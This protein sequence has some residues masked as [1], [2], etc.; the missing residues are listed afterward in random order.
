MPRWIGH[1]TIW[2]LAAGL[3]AA[4]QNAL[5]APSQSAELFD[6]YAQSGETGR[7]TFRDAGEFVSLLGSA[8]RN[9]ISAAPPAER[10]RRRDLVALLALEAAGSAPRYLG[11]FD[12]L[13]IIEWACDLLRKDA[14][15]EF[16]RQWMLASSSLFLRSYYE[17]H[18]MRGPAGYLGGPSAIRHLEHALDRF[19][20]EPRLRLAKILLRP[21]AYA[22]SSRPGTDPDNLVTEPLRRR[23]GGPAG[24]KRIAQTIEA[25][26]ELVDEG[27]VGAEARAHIAWLQFHRG[28]VPASRETFILAARSATDPFVRNLAWLGTGLSLDAEAGAPR[29]PTRIGP[30]S[31]R[32]PGRAH[33]P[34]NLPRTCSWLANGARRRA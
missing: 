27:D 11:H 14:P 17:L 7:L 28:D 3:T 6:R 32:Y 30:P 12:G 24:L 4:G 8:G 2:L 33:L 9:W 26:A 21:E 1:A 29:P 20:R 34:F 23:R 10:E 5:T 18:F 25:L 31:R 19:P 22:L 13:N 15:T 16:E